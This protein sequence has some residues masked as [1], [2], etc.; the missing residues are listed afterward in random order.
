MDGEFVSF[1]IAMTKISERATLRKRVLFWFTIL[2]LTVLE[3]LAMVPH[4]GTFG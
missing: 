1:I 4:C 2:E 3:N